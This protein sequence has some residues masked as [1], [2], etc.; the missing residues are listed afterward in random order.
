[1]IWLIVLLMGV[2]VGKAVFFV[3]G[4]EIAGSAFGLLAMMR[5]GIAGSRLEF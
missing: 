1:M 3:E 4:V 5:H 2:A